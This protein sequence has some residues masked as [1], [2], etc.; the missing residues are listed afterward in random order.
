MKW[1]EATIFVRRWVE[2]VLKLTVGIGNPRVRHPLRRQT[3]S[4]G[5]ASTPKKLSEQSRPRGESLARVNQLFGN[6]FRVS[7]MYLP[8]NTPRR[9]IC[10]GVSSGLNSGSKLRPTAAVRT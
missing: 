5:L 3:D 10:C 9:S 1:P 4:G 6:S 8:Q 7:V 2:K